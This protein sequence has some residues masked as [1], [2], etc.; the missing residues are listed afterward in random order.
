M[1]KLGQVGGYDLP[2]FSK[3][4]IL[5]KKHIINQFNND[6]E[7]AKYLP[8]Q[9]N[10]STVTRSFLL[11]LLFNVRRDKYLLLYKNYKEKK[12][13]ISTTSGKLYEVSISLSFAEK[14]Q[15]YSSNDK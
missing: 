15:N 4:K 10:K 5:T 14:I 3:E 12:K 8:N 1:L 9:I 6:E 13:Q 7:L 2:Y 11:A